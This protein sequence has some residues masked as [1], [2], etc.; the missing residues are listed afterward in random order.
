M[1]HS[2]HAKNIMTKEIELMEYTLFRYFRQA[3]NQALKECLTSF[4]PAKNIPAFNV[5][6]EFGSGYGKA[7]ISPIYENEFQ[8][9]SIPGGSDGC[10]DPGCY[11]DNI[12]YAQREDYVGKI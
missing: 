2:H 5:T 10:A 12:R 7:S 9:T 6:C 3:M 1:P 4:K 8:Y 11:K